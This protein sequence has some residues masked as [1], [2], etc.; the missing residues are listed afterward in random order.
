MNDLY[1]ELVENAGSLEFT[2][3]FVSAGGATE[4][5]KLFGIPGCSRVMLEARMLYAESSFNSFLKSGKNERFVS[6]QMADKLSEQLF[7]NTAASLC[8]S[9]TCALKTNRQRKG[10]DYGYLSVRKNGQTVIQSKIEVEG[11]SRAEQD[12]FISKTVVQH[13]IDFLATIK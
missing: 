4:L 6:Q 11:A 3:A 7:K 12:A 8:F 2:M 10:A 9:L 1:E 5:Y 13:I